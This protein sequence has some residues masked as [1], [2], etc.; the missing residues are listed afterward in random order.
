MSTDL[1]KAFETE[2]AEGQPEA[3]TRSRVRIPHPRRRL[4]NAIRY[5]AEAAE[6]ELEIPPLDHFVELSDDQFR[7]VREQIVQNVKSVLQGVTTKPTVPD[8]EAQLEQFARWQAQHSL[9]YRWA[10]EAM[11][12]L[13]DKLISLGPEVELVPL[14]AMSCGA[15][16]PS[17]R[18]ILINREGREVKS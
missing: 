2:P 5:L 15:K 6:V 18:L 3:K 10:P 4:L 9:Y 16:L 7:G 13:R 8:L 1:D 14:F 12:A 11:A 17:G